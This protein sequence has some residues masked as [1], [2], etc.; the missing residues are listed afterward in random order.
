MFSFLERRIIKQKAIAIKINF[1]DLWRR[2]G[3]RH[4]IENIVPS[5]KH[6]GGGIMVW[7]C[8]SRRGMDTLIRVDRKMNH[9]DYIRI[10]DKHL[11]PLIQSAFNGKGYAFQ[12]DNAPVHTAKGVTNWIREKKIKNLPD[13]PSQSPDLNPIEHLWNELKRRLNNRKKRPKNAT[14]LEIALKE[15][16]SLI[17]HQT[18]SNLIKSMPRRLE[19]CILNNGWPT[20]Y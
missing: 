6:G 5:V 7:G 14:E 17:P 13:W 12:D 4:N 2:A 9:Q 19:A 1:A 3:E 10:L 18:Y 8:F 11:L 16:W 15:E 20:Q